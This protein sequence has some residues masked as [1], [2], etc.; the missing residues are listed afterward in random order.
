MVGRRARSSIIDSI[1]PT[2]CSRR[3]QDTARLFLWPVVSFLVTLGLAGLFRVAMPVERECEGLRPFIAWLLL[4]PGRDV[5][6]ESVPFVVDIP[7][8]LLSFT[9]PFAA[10]S[11]YTIV[12]KLFDLPRDLKDSGLIDEE[13]QPILEEKLH[14]SLRRVLPSRLALWLLFGASLVLVMILYRTNLESGGIFELLDSTNVTDDQLRE[15]WWANF[16]VRPVLAAYTIGLGAIG[17]HYGLA[18]AWLFMVAAVFLFRHS[19]LTPFEQPLNYVPRWRDGSQGW[20]PLTSILLVVYASAISF[21]I[22]MIAVFDMLRFGEV[23]LGPVTIDGIEIAAFF[24]LLGLLTDSTI[25]VVSLYRISSAN[26]GVGDRERLRLSEAMAEGRVGLLT[27]R[28]FYTT[29]RDLEKW[30]TVPV[31]S[32]TLTVAR[33]IPGLLTVYQFFR[34][35]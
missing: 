24:G 31:R 5:V 34:A 29:M 12:R 8:V 35:L 21:L 22:S 25:M 13:R 4:R 14:A 27:D 10:I 6:C 20:A 33:T 23:Q 19:L 1:L 3:S 7:T 15:A 9:C 17:V 18:S 11:Y 28:E 32:R 26:A 30:R 16:R 2:Q